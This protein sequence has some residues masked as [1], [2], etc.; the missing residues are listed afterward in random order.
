M[1][2][3]PPSLEGY[4]NGKSSSVNHDDALT[5]RTETFPNAALICFAVAKRDAILHMPSHFA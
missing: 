2:S 3:I 4:A 5:H 1:G